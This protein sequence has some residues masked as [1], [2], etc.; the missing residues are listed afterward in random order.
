MKLL[1]IVNNFKEW[2]QKNR[3]KDKLNSAIKDYINS[4]DFLDL[5]D[6]EPELKNPALKKR[7]VLFFVEQ[8]VPEPVA[9]AAVNEFL[10]LLTDI[11]GHLQDKA[12][13]SIK[14]KLLALNDKIL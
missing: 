3:V 5:F 11:T 10:R 9:V 8:G 1:G 6:F 14:E 2:Y 12:L 4:K 7:F 13:T